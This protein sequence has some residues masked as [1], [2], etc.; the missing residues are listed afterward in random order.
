MVVPVW[1]CADRLQKHFEVVRRL[2]GAGCSTV[3]VASLSDDNSH[4]LAQREAKRIGGRYILT[5]RGLYKS[6]NKGIKESRTPY[7]YISTVGESVFPEGLAHL[8]DLNRKTK[9]DIVFSPPL[10]SSNKKDRSQI[11]RWPVFKNA[12]KLRIFDQRVLPTN[13]IASIQATAAYSCLL[14][15]LSSCLCRTKFMQSY[16]FPTQFNHYGDTGWFCL[17]LSRCR[18]AYSAR[19]VADFQFHEAPQRMINPAHHRVFLRLLARHLN[20]EKSLFLKPV[21]L[22]YIL[23][24][25]YLDLK[26]G[27]HPKRYWY[28]QPKVFY[29]RILRGLCERYIKA[30]SLYLAK[31]FE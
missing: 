28:L 1:Q 24:L 12:K 20:R 19:A 14:G 21:L 8:L 30:R 7:T 29:V 23:Y 27:T 31:G 9:A 18:I 10:L 22:R 25:R 15:S 16:P 5:P 11:L 13:L 26:R 4:Q 17:N 2:A 3:W 6:W